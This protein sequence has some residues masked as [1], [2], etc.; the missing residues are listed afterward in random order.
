MVSVPVVFGSVN[1]NQI[2][3]KIIFVRLV[4][5]AQ[6]FLKIAPMVGAVARLL[7]DIFVMFRMVFSD[8]DCFEST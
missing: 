3:F 6:I 5:N 7:W 4:K 8:L 2:N 1:L